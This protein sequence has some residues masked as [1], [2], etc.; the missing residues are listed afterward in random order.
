MSTQVDVG[1]GQEVVAVELTY[2]PEIETLRTMRPADNIKD[3]RAVVVAI[4]KA[5]RGHITQDLEAAVLEWLNKLTKLT[6]QDVEDLLVRLERAACRERLD[7]SQ[8]RCKALSRPT[9]IGWSSGFT[10]STSEGYTVETSLSAISSWLIPKG[11]R[12]KT[13]NALHGSVQSVN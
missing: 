7:A 13:R 8:R 12:K 2:L 3:A 11:N 4:A 9:P 1:V 5:V 10:Y 6:E